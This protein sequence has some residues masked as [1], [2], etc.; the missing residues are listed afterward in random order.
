MGQKQG[1]LVM[2]PSSIRVHVFFFVATQESSIFVHHSHL[3]NVIKDVDRA[4]ASVK[5]TPVLL[6]AER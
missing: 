6:A 2:K 1:I 5:Q 3:G 4:G